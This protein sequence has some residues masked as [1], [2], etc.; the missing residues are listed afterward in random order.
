LVIFRDDTIGKQEYAQV[1]FLFKTTAEA[2]FKKTGIKVNILE[3]ANKEAMEATI[4]DKRADLLV[5]SSSLALARG[6]EPVASYG[7]FG[8]PL[9]LECV[10]V[11]KH[12]SFKTLADLKGK[13]FATRVDS[14]S[15]FVWL[16]SMVKGN[17][18]RYFNP[19]RGGKNDGSLTYMLSL[20]QTDG[21]LLNV[22][23]FGLMKMSNPG[24]VKDL[25]RV[26]CAKT[27]PFY[28]AA[29]PRFR[30]GAQTPF[31]TF[32]R[33]LKQEPTMQKIRSLLVTLG[34]ESRPFSLDKHYSCKTWEAELK[35]RYFVK[36][37]EKEFAS[38]KALEA[39]KSG[40]F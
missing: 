40:G 10:Y 9:P 24:A 11:N 7:L 14:E 32:L 16:A 15:R 33:N 26:T 20:G 13:R 36:Q 23:A 18:I 35:D 37:L 34:F 6:Y 25:R 21:V 22:W 28:L 19:L 12:S 3:V 5:N 38:W 17:P 39:K 8:E 4:L 31:V 29:S 27:C 30:K 2:F 1:V